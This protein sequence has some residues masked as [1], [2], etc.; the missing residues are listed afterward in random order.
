MLNQ[1]ESNVAEVDIAMKFMDN[2]KMQQFV[3]SKP[4]LAKKRDFG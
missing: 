2:W 4:Q 3:Q 1:G